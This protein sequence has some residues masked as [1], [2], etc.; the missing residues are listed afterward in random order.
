MNGPVDAYLS[1]L[2]PTQRDCLQTLRETLCA[3]VPQATETISYAMPG[4]RL[5]SGKM[6]AGYAGF[7]R[8]MGLYPHSG[9]VIPLL[10]DDCAGFRTSK[11]GVLFTPDH[12]LPTALV[13]KIIDTRLAELAAGYPP[14]PGA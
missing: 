1:A 5:A 3:Y 7:A 12:P 2:P 4:L 8:R 10:Q 13:H 11:S 6:V 9:S 14:R